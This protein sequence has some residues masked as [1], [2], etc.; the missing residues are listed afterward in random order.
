MPKEGYKQTKKGRSEGRQK[1]L[2]GIKIK[3]SLTMNCLRPSN[4][5]GLCSSLE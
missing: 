5:H 3:D 4:S 2:N 1:R